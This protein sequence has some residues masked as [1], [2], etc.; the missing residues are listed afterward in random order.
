[1]GHYTQAAAAQAIE[2]VCGLLVSIYM[3]SFLAG[4]GLVEVR[5]SF[6]AIELNVE[7]S[8][9]LVRRDLG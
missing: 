7:S 1:M 9:T 2:M 4:W 6:G 3:A 5:D 8:V